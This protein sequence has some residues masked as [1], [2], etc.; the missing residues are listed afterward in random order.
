MRA[1]I[2]VVTSDEQEPDSDSVP[3]TW[4]R[5]A[6]VSRIEASDGYVM[7]ASDWWSLPTTEDAKM[8]LRLV[9]SDGFALRPDGSV[10]T[11]GQPAEVELRIGDALTPL[12]L[13]DTLAL[14]DALRALYETGKAGRR[15]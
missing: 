5:P 7:Y 15:Q 2:L 3:V 1:A 8:R 4:A 12:S 11:E 6:W 9:S 13:E 10:V 14:S